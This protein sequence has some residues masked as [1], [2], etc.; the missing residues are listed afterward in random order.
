MEKKTNPNPTLSSSAKLTACVNG[1][2]FG[3]CIPFLLWFVR[4]RSSSVQILIAMILSS[5]FFFFFSLKKLFLK[6]PA[7]YCLAIYDLAIDRFIFLL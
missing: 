1:C 2:I 3:S 4:N 5:V 7:P 6:S